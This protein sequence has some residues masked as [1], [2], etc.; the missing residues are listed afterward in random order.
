MRIKNFQIVFLGVGVI[1][2]LINLYAETKAL[3]YIGCIC[4]IISPFLPGGF[5]NMH[6]KKSAKEREKNGNDLNEPKNSN[7]KGNSP[8]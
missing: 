5:L 3:W 8:S 2:H 1:L 4:I 6:C 7:T